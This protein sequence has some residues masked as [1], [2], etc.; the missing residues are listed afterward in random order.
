[1]EPS[2]NMP[3]KHIVIGGGGIAGLSYY[4]ALR[5]SAV[6]DI[7]NIDNIQTVYGT[8][9]GAII[10]VML[11]LKYDWETLDNYL[12]KR[13]WQNVFKFDMY[14]II[15]SINKRG[16]FD[17]KILED[18]FTPLFSGKDISINITMQELFDLTKIE[19][20]AF[21][22]ETNMFQT[23]DI[24]HKTHPD[25]KVIDAVYASCSLPIIFCPYLKNDVYYC[26]GGFLLNYPVLA[27]I[28]NGANPL[29]ILGVNGKV[30][31]TD[32]S[33]LTNE[34]LLLDY[35]LFLFHKIIKI[36]IA[37]LTISSIAIEYTIPSISVSIYSIYNTALHMEDR[38][39]LIE[40]G[41]NSVRELTSIV[42]FHSTVI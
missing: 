33:K 41:K 37:P 5:E 32:E 39:K 9:I 1:M 3:I 26:D 23:V 25:W 11:L 13:P 21:S 20:H 31:D 19:L 18:I 22:T 28:T 29:E 36:V 40:H 42:P 7:W 10:A 8:S 14:T 30:T 12:I 16:I 24:S 27:C 34:S 6:L 15:S 4:G 17:I 35:M 2:N 38:I